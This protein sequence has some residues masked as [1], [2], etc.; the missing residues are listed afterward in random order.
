MKRFVEFRLHDYMDMCP[1]KNIRVMEANTLEDIERVSKE[2]ANHMNNEYSGGT[3]KFIKVM[4]REEAQKH[5]N[6]L[7][8]IEVQNP[9]DDSQ[10][11][12]DK[13]N[14]MFN[15]CYN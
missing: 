11:F 2:F 3:T 14:N 12:I 6:N 10:E 5:I 15:E 9:Q 7:I 1:R 4:N 8:D 13:I